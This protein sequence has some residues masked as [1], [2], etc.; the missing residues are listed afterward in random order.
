MRCGRLGGSGSGSGCGCGCAC[1][2]FAPPRQALEGVE[3]DPER[4]CVTAGGDVG[5]G[6]EEALEALEDAEDG[7][8][9]AHEREQLACDVE[10]AGVAD[11]EGFPVLLALC[12]EG[13]LEEAVDDAAL[14]EVVDE[15]EEDDLQMGVPDGG[16]EGGLVK[17]VDDPEALVDDCGLALGVPRRLERQQRH[18]PREQPLLREELAPPG[19][20]QAHLL[21][22]AQ[23]GQEHPEPL[24]LLVPVERLDVPQ[25]PLAQLVQLL[26][27]AIVTLAAALGLA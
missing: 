17:V 16:L 26:F 7:R 18:Q 10:E 5:E 23:E 19:R 8:L 1:A 6:G 24:L 4:P 9:V 13:V 25:V 12:L 14:V 20:C 11:G 21:D 3:D 2:V 15:R 22:P 27:V